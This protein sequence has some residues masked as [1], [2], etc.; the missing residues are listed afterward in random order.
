MTIP[1]PAELAT[2]DI[3][4]YTL[5]ATFTAWAPLVGCLEM[6]ANGESSL[7]G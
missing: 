7:M 2:Q 6:F 1:L 5:H 3:T 4:Q